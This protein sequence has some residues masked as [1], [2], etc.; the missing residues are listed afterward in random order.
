MSTDS[1]VII[2]KGLT[3]TAYRQE[4]SDRMVF[5]T[6][7]GRSFLFYHSQDC[8]E[9]VNIERIEGNL[10]DLIGEPITEA[11]EEIETGDASYGNTFT[12]TSFTFATSKGRVV[13]H[14]HGESNGYYSESVSFVETTKGEPAW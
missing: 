8:C 14:W 11:L 1:N 5:E 2:L 12:K 9:S 3:L 4:G 7:C 13:V 6:S 10:N